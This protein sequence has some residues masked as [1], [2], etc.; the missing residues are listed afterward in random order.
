M[1]LIVKLN[2]FVRLVFIVVFATN[3][4]SD[5]YTV[6]SPGIV[7][8]PNGVKRFNEAICSEKKFIRTVSFHDISQFETG[9]G[10]N[11]IISEIA[12]KFNRPVNRSKMYLGGLKD[13][14]VFCDEIKH[15]N[16]QDNIIVLGCSRGGATT[17][18]AFGI[19]NFKNISA[20]ILDGCPADM[21]LTADPMLAQIGLGSLFKSSIFSIVFPSFCQDYIT[22]LQSIKKIINKNLPILLIHSQDDYIVSYIHSLKLYKEF[23]QQGFNNVYI[24]LTKKGRHAFLLQSPESKDLYLRA[25]HSFYKKYNLPYNAKF[26]VENMDLYKPSLNFIDEKILECEKNLQQLLYKRRLLFFELILSS[27][28]AY[29]AYKNISNYKK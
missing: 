17:V 19:Y 16:E 2:F 5:Y 23:I 28:L 12:L 29:F 22:P 18:S 4:K 24:V 3:I 14:Q 26:A 8:G 6:Y 7:D 20:V 13:V 15:I 25:V 9:Y 11:R 21:L 1:H 27:S 10:I